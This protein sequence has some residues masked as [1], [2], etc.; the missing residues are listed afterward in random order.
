MNKKVGTFEVGR[1]EALNHSIYGNPR[2][3]VAMIDP[4]TGEQFIAKT[5][6]DC[7]IGYAIQKGVWTFVYH[8]TR[9]GAMIITRGEKIK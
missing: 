9:S 6:T 1:L 4:T 7:S 8:Y 5:G 3:L 2:Y